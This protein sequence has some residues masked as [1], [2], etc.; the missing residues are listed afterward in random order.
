MMLNRIKGR[1]LAG[2]AALALGEKANAQLVVFQDN[3]S[4]GSLDTTKWTESQFQGNPYPNT[5]AIDNARGTYRVIQNTVGDREVVL[6]P[7]HNFVVGDTISYSI[8]YNSGSGNN[9][10]QILLNGNYP[11]GEIF[12]NP[13]PN[14]GSGT[15]G[16]WNGIPDTGNQYGAYTITLSFFSDYIKQQTITPSGTTFVHTLLNRT[17]YPYTLG[18]NIHTGHNGLM[19]FEVDN[20]RVTQVPEPATLGIAGLATL[21]IGAG[22]KRKINSGEATFAA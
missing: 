11:M 10:Y 4:S 17:E 20:V 1:A 18:L 9:L 14:P 2:L 5:N 22:L 15:I 8:T 12:P 21:V 3:F 16:Y 6:T 13:T 7:K 19:D